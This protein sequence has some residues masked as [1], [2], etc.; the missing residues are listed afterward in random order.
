LTW[1][2]TDRVKLLK[3]L[4]LAGYVLVK[5]KE[6]QGGINNKQRGTD[7]KMGGLGKGELA[8]GKRRNHLM[9]RKE[10]AA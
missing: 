7:S 1:A 4:E 5:V 2:L 10:T 9:C 6:G 3:P 8:Q